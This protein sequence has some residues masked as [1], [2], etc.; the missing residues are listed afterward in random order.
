MVDPKE[1]KS[2]KSFLD[3]LDDK[4]IFILKP[5]MFK[6]SRSWLN[7]DPKR[8]DKIH[9]NISYKAELV[10]NEDLEDMIDRFLKKRANT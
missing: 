7:N 2:I 9:L 5:N 3:Y 6:D 4:G 8:G 10:S 1:A